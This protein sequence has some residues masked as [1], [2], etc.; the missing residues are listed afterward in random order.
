[1]KIANLLFAGCSLWLAGSTVVLADW[2]KYLD[3][4]KE[5]MST[6]GLTTTRVD[7][8]NAEMVAGL[9]EALDKGV[10]FAVD[11]L[12]KPGGFLG[13]SKVRIPMPKSLSW[14]ES[15]LRTLHQDQLADDFIATMNQAAEQAVPEAADIFSKAIREMSVEDAQG[16]LSGPDDAATNYFRTHT[17]SALNSRMRPIVEAATARAG[18]TAAYKKMTASAGGLSSLLPGSAADIDGYITTKTLDGLFLMIATEE[19]K[20]RTD[21][22]ARSSELMQKVFGAYN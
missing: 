4:A 20:I 21:P 11:S 10:Q 19:H 7:L 8:T 3:T 16:I 9:K 5:A 1:M 22:V 2:S 14:I 13:N 12:G 15:S 18:V 17:E 6:A